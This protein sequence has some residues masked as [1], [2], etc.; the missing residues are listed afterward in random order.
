LQKLQH[1]VVFTQIDTRAQAR[2]HWGLGADADETG[3]LI[4]EQLYNS[5][6]VE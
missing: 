3:E 5:I 4:R 2:N 1:R 6:A